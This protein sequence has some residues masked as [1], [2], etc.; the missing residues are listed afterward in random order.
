MRPEIKCT[1]RYGTLAGFCFL[2]PAVFYVPIRSSLSLS[3]GILLTM[4]AV[5]LVVFVSGHAYTTS[6]RYIKLEE[7]LRK[8][9]RGVLEKLPNSVWILSSDKQEVLFSNEMAAR[10]YGTFDAREGSQSGFLA[11]FQ[12]PDRVDFSA[13]NQAFTLRS[14]VMVDRFYDPRQVDLIVMPVEFENTA[15]LL[16]LAVDHSAVQRSVEENLKLND[17]LV[18]QNERFRSFS[19]LHSHHIRS[20]LA[21]ILGITQVIGDQRE[22]SA[23]VLHML[24]KSTKDLDREVKKINKILMENSGEMNRSSPSGERMGK[25]IIFVDDD[26][27]QHMINKRILMK[28]NP[29]LELVFFENPYEAL[30]WLER[31]VADI[32]LLDINM[33]LMEGWDFLHLMKER[34]INIEVKMLTSSLD[35]R[36]IQKSQRFDMVSGFLVKPLR[37]EVIDEFL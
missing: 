14:L 7:Q 4:M 28:I 10:Y 32:L 22:L 35:P 19:F 23:D 17:S 30:S 18:A 25:V 15:S 33:P 27:V 5:S 21:N 6:I 9:A 13:V 36:D 3:E 26:K 11:L 1:L 37:K 2:V 24:K 12:N 31:N 20:H 29:L 8:Q 16:V 34:G